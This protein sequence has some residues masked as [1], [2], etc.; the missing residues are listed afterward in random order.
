MGQDAQSRGIMVFVRLEVPVGG[1]GKA[2]EKFEQ[3]GGDGGGFR[4]AE[5]LAR[6]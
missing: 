2:V 6:G 5:G 1:G 4:Y 3:E